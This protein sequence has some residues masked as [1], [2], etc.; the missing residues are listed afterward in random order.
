MS[1]KSQ[2]IIPNSQ[3][4]KAMCSSSHSD[5]NGSHVLSDSKPSAH[6]CH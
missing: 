1:F 3:I 6:A 5:S 2:G 4:K